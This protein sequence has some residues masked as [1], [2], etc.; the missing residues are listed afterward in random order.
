M[1]GQN[2]EWTSKELAE[3]FEVDIATF[4]LAQAN[5]EITTA[6]KKINGFWFNVYTETH[7]EMFERYFE[8]RAEKGKVLKK[9]IKAI[10]EEL[11]PVPVVKI[12]TN[13]EDHPLVTD[14][15]CF[16]LNW[17]PDTVPACFSTWED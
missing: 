6:K 1:E 7:K 13:E 2:K 8:I 15:R 16:D 17:W 3:Y 4:H 14:K 12:V 5:L 10:K 9:D 11:A